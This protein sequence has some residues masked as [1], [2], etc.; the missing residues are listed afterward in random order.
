MNKPAEFKFSSVDTVLSAAMVSVMAVG[1]AV[2]LASQSIQAFV[3]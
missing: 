3:A 2:L 1:C